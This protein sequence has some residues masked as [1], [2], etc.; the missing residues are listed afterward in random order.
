MGDVIKLISASP[1]R[2]ALIVRLL[3]IR[4]D[5]NTPAQSAKLAAAKRLL[6]GK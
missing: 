1:G 4:A 3:S 6:G 5:R 2:I